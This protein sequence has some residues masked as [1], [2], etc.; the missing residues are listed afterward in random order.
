MQ[1]PFLLLVTRRW[2][3]I[4]LSHV[5]SLSL[6]S[7][8][9]VLEATWDYLRHLTNSNIDVIVLQEHWLWPFELNLLSTI[10]ADYT[11][12]AVSD[13]RLNGTSDFVRGC[14]GVA[15]LWKKN[16]NASPLQFASDR[17]CGLSIDLNSTSTTPRF[18]PS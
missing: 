14:G 9:G 11:Y 16:L 7:T 6:R 3:R 18:Y 12:T 5:V 1:I 13:N 2:P 10:G 15:I 4:L 8:A 17:M